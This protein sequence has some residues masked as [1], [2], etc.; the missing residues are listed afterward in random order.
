VTKGSETEVS[1]KLINIHISYWHLCQQQQQQQ[2][3]QQKDDG[4]GGGE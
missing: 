3:Q 1:L 2:Q 4:W